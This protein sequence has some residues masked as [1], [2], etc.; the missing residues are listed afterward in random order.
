[1][2]YN[3]DCDGPPEGR[4]LGLQLRFGCRRAVA[5]R[6]WRRLTLNA[7]DGASVSDASGGKLDVISIFDSRDV[8]INGFAI[9]AGSDGV[10]GA[11]GISC[12]DWS[13]CRLALNVI[14]GAG[15]GAG[16]AVFQA[17][18]ATV[19]GDTFQNNG[20]GLIANSGSKVRPG[21]QT[22]PITSQGNGTGIQTGRQG[23]VFVLATVQNNSGYGVNVPLIRHGQKA[24]GVASRRSPKCSC[25]GS[26][27]EC[28][29]RDWLWR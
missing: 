7:I 16:F 14:Q 13:T 26:S 6:E 27:A 1:M 4:L 15:S 25:S 2:I 24:E 23:F 21:G 9:N 28:A 20:V 11:N 29:P 10:S 3:G 22:R 5:R 8:T 17:S 18:A 19:D 12:N